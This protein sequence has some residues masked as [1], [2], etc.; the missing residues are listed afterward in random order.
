MRDRVLGRLMSIYTQ[1]ADWYKD[2]HIWNWVEG[3][4]N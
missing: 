3:V 2:G 1:P 4:G